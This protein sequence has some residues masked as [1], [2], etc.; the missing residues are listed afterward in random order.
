M[1]S[2]G[3]VFMRRLSGSAIVFISSIAQ[4]VLNIL[5]FSQSFG[6]M[7]AA[8]DHYITMSVQVE[9][10]SMTET[11]SMENLF[12]SKRPPRHKRELSALYHVNIQNGL[13]ASWSNFQSRS[14]LSDPK[15]I[16][17]FEAD[18]RAVCTTDRV[19]ITLPRKPDVRSALATHYEDGKQ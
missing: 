14:R 1:D 6:S 15:N 12:I 19:F 13:K 2:V 7:I 3:R 10:P 16:Q 11:I 17:I 9:G 18:D 4:G 5:G 8:S